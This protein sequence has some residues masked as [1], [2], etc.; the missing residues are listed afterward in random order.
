MVK[1]AQRLLRDEAEAHNFRR[2]R[3][4]F[5]E[6]P[7]LPDEVKRTAESEAGALGFENKGEKTMSVKNAQSAWA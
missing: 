4:W 5:I 1:V 7:G 2:D 3:L 6:S